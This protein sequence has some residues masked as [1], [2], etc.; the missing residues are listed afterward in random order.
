MKKNSILYVL[1][2]LLT[3][4]SVTSR[5]YEWRGPDRSGIYNESNLLK[6]WPAQGP[7]KLWSVNT[8]GN[9]F[10]SPV[11]T[12]ENFYITGEVDS[13]EVLF[14]YNLKGEKQWQA[15]LGREWMK[16]FPGSRSAPTIVDNLLYV[17]T[18]LGN[19][20]CIDRSNGRIIWSKILLPTLMEF[21]LFTGILNLL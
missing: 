20:F 3:S 4:S 2:L 16:S 13:M 12:D 11:F 15:T 10:V 19:L 18:G 6:T 1:M 5:I 7:K 17:G 8:I 9:G 14:S 21:F